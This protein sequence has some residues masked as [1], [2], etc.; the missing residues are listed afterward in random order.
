MT[1]RTDTRT[2]TRLKDLG[3]MLVW[4]LTF[5]L[6]IH[7]VSQPYRVEGRSMEG[8]LHDRE[9]IWV[10]RLDVPER[11]EVIVFQA[12]TEDKAYVKRVI[13]L[14]GERVLIS[15]GAVTINGRRLDEPYLAGAT[16]CEAA[17]DTCDLIVPPG[18][19]FVLG[20]NRDNS[21]D[22][23]AWGPLDLDR[24]VGR[25]WMVYWP[26]RAIGRIAAP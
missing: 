4:S 21:S 14:P 13:G 10:N 18:T 6:V 15:G 5:W 22:S 16:P 8:T 1:P 25:A 9:Q 19:V 17:I 23:R 3:Q 7:T 26:P 24:V 20:D 2:G 11:G 12:P